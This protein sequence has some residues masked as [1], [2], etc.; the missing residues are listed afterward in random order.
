ML[1]CPIDSEHGLSSNAVPDCSCKRGVKRV[2]EHA[3]DICVF[4]ARKGFC[5]LLAKVES[6]GYT[7][8]S[9]RRSGNVVHIWVVK[10]SAL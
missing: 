7:P 9:Q 4:Q 10:S 5:V 3:T 2:E 1:H 8:G 6:F